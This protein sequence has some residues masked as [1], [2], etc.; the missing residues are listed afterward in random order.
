MAAA[1][2][3]GSGCGCGRGST[4]STETCQTSAQGATSGANLQFELFTLGLC[5]KVK[6]EKNGTN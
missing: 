5:F 6:G 1:V 4:A 2:G 3:C